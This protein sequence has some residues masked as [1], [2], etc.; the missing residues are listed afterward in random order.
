MNERIAF[1][2]LAILLAAGMVAKNNSLEFLALTGTYVA[3]TVDG[4][5]RYALRLGADGTAELRT[6][7][8][9]R[10][11]DAAP[12]T[13]AWILDGT[14][15][16]VALASGV[17]SALALTLHS[18]ERTLVVTGSDSSAPASPLSGLTFTKVGS[19]RPVPEEN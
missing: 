3:V 5:T 9:D 4:T 2:A 13:G 16:Q 14:T 19:E 17:E 18:Q 11:P 12:A 1:G 8:Y 10:S 7:T 6:M 15:V